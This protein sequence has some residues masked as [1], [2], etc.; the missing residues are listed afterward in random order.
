MKKKNLK[1]LSRLAIAGLIPTLFAGCGKGFDPSNNVTPDIYG[2]PEMYEQYDA[3]ENAE[4]GVYGAP[5]MY[6]ETVSENTIPEYDI[7]ENDV[8]ENDVSENDIS[9]NNISSFIKAEKDDVSE[10]DFDPSENVADPIYG[11]PTP[12]VTK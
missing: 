8:S 6:E 1:N 11:A 2:G 7:S 9:E 3:R 10:D 4:P 5:E 12:E